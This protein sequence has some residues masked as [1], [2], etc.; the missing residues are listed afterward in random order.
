MKLEVNLAMMGVL[1]VLLRRLEGNQNL[2]KK[3]QHG[4][5]KRPV[6]GGRWSTPSRIIAGVYDA[7]GTCLTSYLITAFPEK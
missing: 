7:V 2:E 5:N 6:E 1:L 4:E 3:G